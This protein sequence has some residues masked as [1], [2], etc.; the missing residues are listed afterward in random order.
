MSKPLNA[1]FA[2]VAVLC[3][4][5]G[6]AYWL[7]GRGAA[8]APPTKPLS[9]AVPPTSVPPENPSSLPARTTGEVPPPPSATAAASA[10]AAEPEPGPFRAGEVLE[11][12]AD[13]AKLSNVADLRLKI[14][15]HRNFFGKNAY[16][17]QAFAR[18]ENPL[19]MMFELDDQFDSYSDAGSLTSLQYEM[20]LSER[21][22]KVDL[23]QRMTTTAKDPASA[24]VTQAIVLPGTRDPLGLMQYLR[25]VDWSKTREVTGPV[26]DGHKLY[27]VK[28]TLA[29]ASTPVV[30]PAGHFD[31]TKVEIRVFQNGA[32]LSDA[33]FFAYISHDVARTPVMLEAVMPFA[34]ARVVLT[35]KK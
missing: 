16:H 24:G 14:V 20:H 32:E 23:V 13:V 35:A 10:S 2:A 5:A 30:V 33:H 18:T 28:S 9:A 19:R 27:D 22:Q 17:L 8:G 25:S 29:S 11:Y 21:G 26:Y 7:Y 6:A 3:L 12:A 15:E 4:S 1:T 34:T 31:A